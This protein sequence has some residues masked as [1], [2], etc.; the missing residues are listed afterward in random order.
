MRCTPAAFISAHA[1]SSEPA[2]S[3][4]RHPDSTSTVTKP[5]RRVHRRVMHAKVGRNPHK[6]DSPQTALAQVAGQAGG[7]ASI[8]LIERGIRID[9]RSEALADDELGPIRRQLRMKGRSRCT[10]HTMIGP[11]GLPAIR[12]VNRFESSRTRM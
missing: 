5:N 11:K 3:M 10:L 9:R 1:A 7:S 2:K 4:A 8:V 6:E 12:H